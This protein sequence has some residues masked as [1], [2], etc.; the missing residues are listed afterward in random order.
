MASAPRPT[1]VLP[2]VLALRRELAPT[3]G[4]DPP[5]V[6]FAPTA[7]ARDPDAARDQVD[8]LWARLDLGGVAGAVTDGVAAHPAPVSGDPGVPGQSPEIRLRADADP[9]RAARVV[10]EWVAGTDL[11]LYSPETN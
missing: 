4:G 11:T 10:G 3:V 7:F 6:R 9:A 5:A 1:P 8:G 2:A